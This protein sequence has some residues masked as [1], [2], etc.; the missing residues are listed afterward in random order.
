MK[1]IVVVGAGITGLCTMYRLQKELQQ[2]NKQARL[3]LIEKNDY[4]GGKIHSA[5]EDGFILETGAD[6]MVARHPGV[7]VSLV[8]NQSLYITKRVCPISIQITSYMRFQQ[9]QHSVFQ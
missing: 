7:F 9:V 1:T 8:L 3:I 2:K 5:Y 6:S 4:V